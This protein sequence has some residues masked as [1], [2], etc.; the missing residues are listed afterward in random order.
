MGLATPSHKKFRAT[1]AETSTIT[2]QSVRSDHRERQRMTPRPPMK[3][4][5]PKACVKIEQWNVRT[6]RDIGK[7]A[8]VVS[9][10][11]RVN[12]DI[13]VIS[14]MRWNGCGKMT[15]A[16]GETILYSGKSDEVGHHEQGVGLTFTRRENNILM[17]GS[18]F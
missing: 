10:M 3:L 7:C 4:F 9:E 5:S 17:E 16:T 1:E 13:L 18:P 15:A 2:N 12:L 11:Q 14:E 8:Q 6:M